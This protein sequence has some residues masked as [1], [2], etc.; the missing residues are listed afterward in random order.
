MKV[1]IWR[2]YLKRGLF[3]GF[4]SGNFKTI[5]FSNFFFIISKFFFLFLPQCFS[6]LVIVSIIDRAPFLLLLLFLIF[7]FLCFL[8]E[9]RY[10]F[11][12]SVIFAITQ[13]LGSHL[14]CNLKFGDAILWAHVFFL[15]RILFLSIL[16]LALSPQFYGRFHC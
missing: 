3:M 14:D 10:Q 4:E 11:A 15:R 9:Y 7:S 5:S 16:I 1:L 8:L 6:P 2:G 13:S 12:I